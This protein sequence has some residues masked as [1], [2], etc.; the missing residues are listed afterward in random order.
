MSDTHTSVVGPGPGAGGDHRQHVQ[1]V[2]AA[3]NTHD[4]AKFTSFYS[5]D[6]IVH[7]PAA[8]EPLRGRTGV[9]QDA[10]QFITAMPDLT[11]QLEELVPAEGPTV[12]FRAL[13]VGTHTGPMIMP[14]GEVP[15]T[16]RRASIAIAVFSRQGEDGLIEEEHRY[17]D[18]MG[19]AQQL[20]LA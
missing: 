11:M 8:P 7:D 18:L 4:A 3:F 16:G 5:P 14:T 20:G 17:Y 1:E 12:A 2:I 15:P 10:Q 9:Q 19:L 6:A 13:L